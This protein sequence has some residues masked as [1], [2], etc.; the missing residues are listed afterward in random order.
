MEK[1]LKILIEQSKEALA[2]AEDKIE[3]LSKEFPD[4]AVAFWGDMKKHFS[5]IQ[6]KLSETY[7]ELEGNAELKADLGMMEA[8][9]K[10][11]TIQDT[12]DTFL[13]QAS[14]NTSTK[15]DIAA[16]KAHLAKKESEDLW[17]EKQKKLSHLYGKSKV[18]VEKLANKAGKEFNDIFLKLTDMV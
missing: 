12:L 4:D 6:E 2:K 15:F 8:R 5:G 9:E 10:L 16:L 14:K 7:T 13:H 1:E 18:E 11:S 17:E 3:T